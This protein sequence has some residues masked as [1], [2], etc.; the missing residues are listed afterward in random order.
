MVSK[1]VPGPRERDPGR[2]EDEGE[3]ALEAGA[4]VGPGDLLVARLAVLADE[5]EVVVA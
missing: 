2:A 5:E 4:D 3:G 1:A